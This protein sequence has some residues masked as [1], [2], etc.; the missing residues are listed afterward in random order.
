M[1]IGI[2]LL[3]DVVENISN[4]ILNYD[5]EIVEIHHNKKKIYLTERY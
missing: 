1:L 3:L 5:V 2:N 4:K